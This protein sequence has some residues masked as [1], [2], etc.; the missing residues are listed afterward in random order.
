VRRLLLVGVLAL[1]AAALAPG[2]AR[3]TNECRGFL[4][5]VPVAGPWVVV[6]TAAAVP[7]PHVDWQLT[8]PRGYV[9]GGLDAELSD[10]GI[11]LSFGGTLGSPVNPGITTSRS[12]VFVGAYVLGSARAPTFRPHVGCIPAQ[13]GGGRI[14]TAA[15]A[16]FPPGKPAERRTRTV[17]IRPGRST[18]W[19][20]CTRGERLVAAAHA[21]GV[22]SVR[23][24]SAAIAG[25]VRVA[26]AV[27]GARVTAT[28]RA[29]PAVGSARALVQVAAVCAG[30]Q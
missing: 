16:V 22:D 1:A 2:S 27:R 20:A 30:G 24:P 28:V 3:A 15:H 21:V 11:D 26:R 14:P 12:A 13:G 25:S 9:V 23:P 5:C 6:P 10:R 29:G 8:C 19:V 17:R 18:V 7:R 4:V